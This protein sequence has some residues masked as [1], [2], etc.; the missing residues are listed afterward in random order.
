MIA[1]TP[2]TLTWLQGVT[3][4]GVAAALVQLIRISMNIGE[5]KKELDTLWW[6]WLTNVSNLP[7]QVAGSPARTKVE[8]GMKDP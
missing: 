1:P 8:M 6:W 5:M 7:H 3:L 2:A 4:A